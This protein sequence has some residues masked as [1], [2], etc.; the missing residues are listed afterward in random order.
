MNNYKFIGIRP[1]T[2]IQSS[3]RRRPAS[4]IDQQPAE[5]NTTKHVNEISEMKVGGYYLGKKIRS[6]PFKSKDAII[7]HLEHD[8]EVLYKYTNKKF[9]PFVSKLDTLSHVAEVKFKSIKFDSLTNLKVTILKRIFDE[10]DTIELNKLLS[11]YESAIEKHL[12]V[13]RIIGRDSHFCIFQLEDAT[14]EFRH[15][16]SS[17]EINL[18]IAEYTRVQAIAETL[19]PEKEQLKFGKRLA[20]ALNY[21]FK[22]RSSGEDLFSALERVAAGSLQNDVRLKLLTITSSVAIV[23][24][25]LA[26]GLYYISYQSPSF[27][28]YCL[29]SGTGGIAGA[30]ISFLERSK[31]TIINENDLALLVIS[32]SVCRI[33]LGGLFGAIACAATS[34]ELAFSLFKSSKPALLI[35]GIAAGFSERLI[36]DVLDTLGSKSSETL[37]AQHKETSSS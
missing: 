8:P 13:K 4:K 2:S 32:N 22:S 18:A 19:L 24:M 31:S 21:A 16:Q 27:A 29:I 37:Q 35:L 1:K 33:L 6:I 12:G 17:D 11:I 20:A 7:F 9:S 3:F 10:C 14:F 25:F 36:P 23:V 5:N 28:S 30:L 15:K 34:A 26:T